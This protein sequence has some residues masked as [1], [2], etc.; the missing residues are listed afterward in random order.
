MVEGEWLFD[1]IKHCL[2]EVQKI[3]DEQHNTRNYECVRMAN[4]G[5]NGICRIIDINRYNQHNT[6]PPQMWRD[7][8]QNIIS[9]AD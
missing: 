7:H 3:V 4:T 9:C 2:E 6:N 5:F 1:E 8:N